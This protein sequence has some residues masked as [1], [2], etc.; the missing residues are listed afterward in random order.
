MAIYAV[1]TNVPSV[2]ATMPLFALTCTPDEFTTTPDP[3]VTK[4][5][6][7]LDVMPLFALTKFALFAVSV[8]TFADNPA[9]D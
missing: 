2:F 4:T 5:P 8:A 7:E 3:V 6:E 1:F 9:V